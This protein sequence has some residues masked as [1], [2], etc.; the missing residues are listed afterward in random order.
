MEVER[1]I[2]LDGPILHLGLKLPPNGEVLLVVGVRGHDELLVDPANGEAFAEG[3]PGRFRHSPRNTA[4][5][6]G[7]SITADWAGT[8]YSVTAHATPITAHCEVIPN[9]PLHVTAS[10]AGNIRLWNL[11]TGEQLRT[12]SQQSPVA[13]VLA[14]TGPDGRPR[15]AT[16]G[17]TGQ[18]YI[19]DPRLPG[20]QRVGQVATRGFSDRVA[21]RDLL[22]RSALVQA[23]VQLLEPGAD[24]GPTVITVEGAWGSGKSTLLEFVRNE[25]APPPA[26][27]PA[28]RRLTVLG[29]DRMLHRPPVRA[30]SARRTPD[31]PLVVPFNPWRH[32]SSEQVWAGLATAIADAVGQATMPD[33]NSTERYWFANNASRVD[34]RHLQRQ[35]WKRTYSPLSSLAGLGFGV[36]LLGALTKLNLTWAFWPSAALAAAGAL[37]T[38]WRW[39]FSRASAFLPGELFSGPVVSK[40]FSGPTTDPLIRDPY[41]HA[42]S[43]YLYLVQ[44]DVKA[45]L[46][47]LADK[48]CQLVLLIDDLDRCTPSTT[49]QVFEAINVF[50]ADDFPASRFVLGLDSS[51][52]AAHVDHAYKELA[53]AKVVAHPDD[54][55]PGWTFLRK[56][57]QLPVRLPR[58]TEDDVDQVLLAQL[59]EVHHDFTAGA[60]AVPGVEPVVPAAGIAQEAGREDLDW[61]IIAIERHAD[62]REHL[63]R[64]LKAQPEQSVREEKRLLNLWQFYLRVLASADVEQACHLVIVAEIAVRWPAYLHRLRGGWLDLADAVDDDVRWGATIAK[65]GY[66]YG[67]R[68]AA[69]NLRALLQDCDA[70]AVAE[71]ANR[72]S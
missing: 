68:T 44:H 2:R 52:V 64:R 16:G 6:A 62:V 63:R 56:L 22:N 10:E 1:V 7:G 55:S 45:L 67:D 33:Q 38:A 57:V 46:E 51:V 32:Q 5:V 54:P 4:T 31:R 12:G 34:R 28:G 41:Y 72:L 70:H 15:I 66:S 20:A 58:T 43:G 71:L 39:L 18:L 21:N 3:N 8:T 37:H 49:A 35:L 9:S 11:R 19:W 40:A 27:L 61:E 36:S 14:F 30:Q 25:L 60:E 26:E 59:G 53:D 24:D 50:L 13:A 29:A 65:L 48:G 69:A 23:L 47:D 42:R 17:A